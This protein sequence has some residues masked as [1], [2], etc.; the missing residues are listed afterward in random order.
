MSES[1]DALIVPWTRQNGALIETGFGGSIPTTLEGG[2]TLVAAVMVASPK[3]LPPRLPQSV[4]AATPAPTASAAKP[5]PAP[6]AIENS[7]RPTFAFDIVSSLF[8]PPYASWVAKRR[9]A[10]SRPI[11]EASL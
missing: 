8:R 4:A 9:N 11:L 5:A 7:L 3:V 10:L 1:A 2:A 6:A